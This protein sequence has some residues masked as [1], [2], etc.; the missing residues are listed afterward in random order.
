M[1][2]CRSARIAGW[3]DCHWA[4]LSAAKGEEQVSESFFNEQMSEY[5]EGDRIH[6]FDTTHSYNSTITYHAHNEPLASLRARESGS[7]KAQ[8]VNGV[9]LTLRR[10]ADVTVLVLC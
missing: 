10:D 9:T 4:V 7:E 8:T 5:I 3:A 2:G 1:N 6:L